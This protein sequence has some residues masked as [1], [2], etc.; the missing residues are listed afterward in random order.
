M[1]DKLLNFFIIAMSVMAFS[2]C[3]EKDE[4][5][6]KPDPEPQGPVER[7]V[8]V[9]M[10]ADNNLGTQNGLNRADLKEMQTG[11]AEGQLNGGRLLVYHN[12]PGTVSSSPTTPNNPPLL[13]EVTPTGIDTLKTY[14]DDPTIYSVEVDRMREVLADMKTY[15]PPTTMVS[16]S[17]ATPQDG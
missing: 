17:G 16:C 8:L 15:A 11:A 3:G 10:V 6:P 14:P 7:T 9:Y 12:R 5:Q 13:L 2:S 1:L 4:P